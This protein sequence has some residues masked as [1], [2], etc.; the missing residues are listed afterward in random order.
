M[1]YASLILSGILLVLANCAAWASRQPGKF[2]LA[3]AA[4]VFVPFM[5]MIFFPAVLLQA[6]L[7][8]VVSVLWCWLWLGKSRRAFL[9]LSCTAT[10][11]AY[12][13]VGRAAYQDFASLRQE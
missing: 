11:A 9:W 1:L 5:M 3:I 10:L 12:A 4:I 8:F 13:F 2:I 6:L 7:L